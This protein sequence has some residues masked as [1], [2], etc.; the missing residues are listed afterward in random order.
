MNRVRIPADVE[1]EDRLL[2]GLSARQLAILAV[3]GVVLW[4][5]YVATRAFLPLP[6]FAACTFPLATAAGLLALGRRDGLSADRLVL[7]ALRQLRAPRRLVP[8]PEGV[9][10]VPP[11]LAHQAQPVPARL[12]LP[13]RGLDAR[14]VVDLG[15]EGAALVCAASSLNLGLRTEVEKEAVV[16]AF[17]RFLNSVTAPLQIVVRAERAD[18]SQVIAAIEEAAGGLLHAGLE[19]AAREHARFLAELAAR[20]DVLG[21]QVLL[22]LREP[23]SAADGGTDALLRRAA[24]ATSSLAAAGITVRPLSAEESAAVLAGAADPEGPS[25]P[26]R[27]AAPDGVITRG[28]LR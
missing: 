24:E 19:T 3:A 1:R 11:S 5:V 13:V 8:V 20:R 21:R 25:R 12:D 15:E 14:G 26:G 10:P 4:G 2:A 7:A 22:V 27:Q 23:K 9:A 16:A 28:G 18:L 17:G 6:L